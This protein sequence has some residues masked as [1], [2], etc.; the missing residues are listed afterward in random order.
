VLEQVIRRGGY[1]RPETA[2]E[3]VI[4]PETLA[5]DLKGYLVDC[6]CRELARDTILDYEKFIGEFVNWLAGNGVESSTKVTA[7]HIRLFLVRK[8]ET[9]K[10]ES[11]LHYYR[12]LR[13]FFNFLVRD[14]ILGRNPV[15]AVRPPKADKPLI[16]PFEPEQIQALLSLCDYSFLGLRNRAIIMLFLDTMLRKNELGSIELK[17]VDFDSELILVRNAK[18]RKERYVRMGKRCQKALLRYLNQRHD[19]EPGLWVSE[20]RTALLPGAIAQ[21]VTKLGK[22]AGISGVRCSCHTLRHTGA[23]MAMENGA[24]ERQVQEL[25]GHSTSAMTRRYTATLQ[26]KWAAEAHKRFSPADNLRGL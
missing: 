14:G 21:M 16:K 5:G 25:L 19:R 1:T 20:E 7:N 9:C 8:Q 10:A 22:R 12:N 24:Q 18:G 3:L 11:I 23:T 26:S 4:R 6:R 13:A 15:L 2:L 17:D